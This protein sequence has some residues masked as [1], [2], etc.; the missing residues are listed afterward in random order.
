MLWRRVLTQLPAVWPRQHRRS[1]SVWWGHGIASSVVASAAL[2][3]TVVADIALLVCWHRRRTIAALLRGWRRLHMSGSRHDQRLHGWV[4]EP[5]RGD[6]RRRRSRSSGAAH[7]PLVLVHRWRR[8]IRCAAHTGRRW[9][10][11]STDSTGATGSTTTNAV[12]ASVVRCERSL[13]LRAAAA[14]YLALAVALRLL[15]TVHSSGTSPTT[16][17][18]RLLPPSTPAGV[19]LF[20]CAKLHL[21]RAVQQVRHS[22]DDEQQAHR[23]SHDRIKARGVMSIMALLVYITVG[24]RCCI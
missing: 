3:C 16:A 4:H 17:I 15:E 2:R 9:S 23:A 1:L 22:P 10:S 5:V 12:A 7:T 14:S 8:P 13:R 24:R 20:V 18:P 21:A 19:V 6:V 11:G